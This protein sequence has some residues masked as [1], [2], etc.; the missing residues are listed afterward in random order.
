M[1]ITLQSNNDE[2]LSCVA[3]TISDK[4][5]IFPRE[6]SLAESRQEVR[7]KIPNIRLVDT[8]SVYEIS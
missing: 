1:L 3:F 5:Y 6:Y 4:S 2:K 8:Q 7:P